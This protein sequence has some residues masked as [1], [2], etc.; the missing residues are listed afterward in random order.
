MQRIAVR[1]S[2]LWL[3]SAFLVGCVNPPPPYEDYAIART[4]VRSARDFDS[5][6]YSTTTL[7]K[8]EEAFRNGEKCFKD[9]DFE[10]AK[11]YFRLAKEFAERAEN[12]TRLKKFKSGD[13]FP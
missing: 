11:R 2:F 12:A 5:A 7:H 8:A 9:N 6:R 1:I 10:Q 4:A 3:S 13:S